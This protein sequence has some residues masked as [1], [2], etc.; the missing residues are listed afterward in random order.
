M[1]ALTT[2]DMADRLH[3]LT[4]IRRAKMLSLRES[5]ELDAIRHHGMKGWTEFRAK[6]ATRRARKA[7]K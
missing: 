3:K 5:A 1:A 7:V 4:A 2:T 6:C